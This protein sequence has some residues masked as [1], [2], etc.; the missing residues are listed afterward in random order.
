[1]AASCSCFSGSSRKAKASAYQGPH[2]NTPWGQES[3]HR[4][5]KERRAT[6]GSQSHPRP[7]F[8]SCDWVVPPPWLAAG[9][10]WL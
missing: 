8:L 5:G 6:E 2:L 7:W 10:S 3:L 9:C 4:V 1:M